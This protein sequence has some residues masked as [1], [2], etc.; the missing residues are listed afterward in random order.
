MKASRNGHSDSENDIY[1]LLSRLL[2]CLFAAVVVAFGGHV[3][4]LTQ[5]LTDTEHMLYH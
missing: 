4:G 2:T 3:R 5:D 1:N